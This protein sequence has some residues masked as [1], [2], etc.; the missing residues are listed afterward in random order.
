MNQDKI[1]KEL[2]IVARELTAASE[3]DFDELPD[4]RQALVKK[5]R[6]KPSQVWDGIHGYIVTAKVGRMDADYI[7]K[8]VSD[9]NFRW[10]QAMGRDEIGIGF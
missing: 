8:L 6:I 3:I 1:A 2:I 4:D 5:M 7:K 9:R 10:M